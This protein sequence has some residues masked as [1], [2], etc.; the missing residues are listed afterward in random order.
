MS[1]G[2]VL[3]RPSFKSLS[4]RVGQQLQQMIYYARILEP[5]EI[6]RRFPT[7]KRAGF[8]NAPDGEDSVR[9]SLELGQPVFAVNLFRSN[10]SNG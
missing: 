4:S 10:G 9:C 6:L 8:G 5:A 1:M 2:S 7:Q 3:P